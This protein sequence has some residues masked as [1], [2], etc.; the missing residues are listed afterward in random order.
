MLLLPDD[1]HKFQ[2]QLWGPYRVLKRLGKVSYEIDIPERGTTKVIHSNL[3]KRW[4][5]REQEEFC[6]KNIVEVSE[7]LEEYQWEQNPPKF[8]EQL[9]QER[10]AIYQLLQ[11][12]PTIIAKHPGRTN[13]TQH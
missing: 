1:T 4:H 13:Q 2:Q 8:G 7:D 3:L 5:T 11:R 10:R 12:F 6:Y 9:S